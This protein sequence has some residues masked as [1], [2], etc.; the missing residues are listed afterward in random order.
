MLF[1]HHKLYALQ[2]SSLVRLLIYHNFD[3]LFQAIVEWSSEKYAVVFN[4]FSDN[5]LGKSY[6]TR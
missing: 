2:S 3:D 6:R 5:L 4:S 1:H